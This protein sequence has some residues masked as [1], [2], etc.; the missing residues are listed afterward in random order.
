[1]SDRE[2]HSISSD[3]GSSQNIT[4]NIT[5]T[6][7]RV[8]EVR[9]SRR[10]RQ[11]DLA[12]DIQALQILDNSDDCI[13]I[14]DV[15]GQI[16]FMSAGGQALLGIQDVTPFL[17]TSWA[18]FWQGA[19]RLAA[20][21]AIA[22][23]KVGEISTFE[24]YCPTLTGEPKWWDNKIS[25]IREADGQIE[26][27][28][29]ISRDV[30]ERRR[31]EDKRQQ[32]E[33]RLRKS[34]ARLSAIFSQAAVGLS[35][36]SLDGHF[37]RI[38]DELCRILGRSREEMLAIGVPEVTHPEDVPKSLEAFKRLVET[39][40]PVSL[41]KRYLRPDGT[42]LW[43]RSSLTRLDDEQ[44]H[45]LTVLAVTV[46]LTHRQ[47][48]EENLRSSEERYRAI[49]DR[50]LTGVAYSDLNGQL[51]IVN[52]KYCDITGY[53]AA[54]LRQMRIHDLT[55]PED[56]PRNV[57]LYNRMLAE[58]TPFEIEQRYIRKD[59][60]IVWINNSVSAI[61]DREGNPQSIVAIVLDINDRKQAE[62]R[63]IHEAFHDGLTGL[64]NRALFMERLERA[65]VRTK[66]HADYKF[67]VLFLDLDRF[68]VVN[69][70]L[71]HEVG[72][73]LL[74]SLAS[75][76]EACL[77]SGD[78]VARLGG[79]E[80]TILLDEIEDTDRVTEIVERL[81]QDLTS[82]FNL[83][84][85]EIFT[86]ASIGIA[87]CTSD[88]NEP[89]ELLR[90]ADIAMYRAKKLGRASYEIFDSMMYEAAM[91][92]LQLE[93]N[94]RRAIE[95]QEFEIHYQ[96]I[97]SLLTKKLVGFEALLRWQ[98]PERGLISPAQFIPLAEETGLIVEIGYWVLKEA[99]RQLR[100]WQRQFCANPLTISVNLSSQQFLQPDLIEQIARILQETELDASSLKLEITESV[101]MENTQLA[102][103]MLLQL[104][105]MNLGIHIDDF[106]TG[107]SSLSYL[108]RF[109]SSALKIDR[110]F[111]SHMGTEPQNWEIVRAIVTL[112]DSL[113]IDAIAE[114]VETATQ[115]AQL[116]E[117][118]CKYAQ[119]Y[120][121]SHPLDSSAATALIERK[122]LS[123]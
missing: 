51:T 19:E 27:L 22:K 10:A 110:S 36:I 86:S 112:A 14:L 44:G 16:L 68:K 5:E 107:Y 69:D 108:H 87:I 76:L 13:K 73:L 80:F 100:A 67:A 52:Q 92:V 60:S 78:T 38:N 118:N 111:V 65:L 66:R 33:E 90:D 57:K 31:S 82:P 96:P 6:E 122:I 30:T 45:P 37:L 59:G 40:E 18:E 15:E 64:P 120:F 25:P 11:P 85:S 104:R 99:C 23:A 50:A 3:N 43:G 7:V 77:R 20:L 105:E 113:H 109:P 93:T 79:D 56:L 29:C 121:F 91:N 28:L 41:D 48:A 55:H 8:T 63:L 97:V 72:D 9:A 42:L 101:L 39:G 94:L 54:E 89:E 4:P 21:E 70:S 98:Q 49:I 102:T 103:A 88:Y 71:G 46:D 26:R 53:S 32:A 106:G 35:E 115:L 2:D 61:C 24:G 62:A 123:S 47:Q 34:E 12:A 117:L 17:N 116:R 81:H 1:M 114:G 83:N 75:R 58:N 84:G 74:I 119:G 95:R